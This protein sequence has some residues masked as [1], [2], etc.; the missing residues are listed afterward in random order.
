MITLTKLPRL[1][2]S[3]VIALLS[4]ILGWNLLVYAAGPGDL[5]PSFGENGIVITPVEN[6][7]SN[8]R[9]VALQSDGKIV[10]AG[11]ASSGGSGYYDIAVARYTITGSLDTSFDHDGI[12]TTPIG[13]SYDHGEAI[14]IQ[15]D[16]KIVVAGDSDHYGDLDFVVARYTITGSLDSDFNGTG[17]VTTPISREDE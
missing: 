14:A 3:L 7:S 10:V 15:P 11:F 17:I 13:T 12:V 8:G 4:L 16:G 9:S 6:G 2:L 1:L 5:D